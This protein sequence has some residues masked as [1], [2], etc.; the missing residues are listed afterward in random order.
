MAMLIK[1]V[2]LLEQI[3]Y[4]SRCPSR[5][6][7]RYLIVFGDMLKLYRNFLSVILDLL[8]RVVVAGK[9]SFFFRLWKL[10]LKHEN[11]G[12]LGNSK[13]LNAQE[14][15]VSQQCFI[16]I[17]ISCHFVV[18][19]IRHFHDKYPHLSVPLYLIGS[20]S[21][22]I[23][24]SKVEGMQGM[25]RAYDFHEF[26][27]CANTLNQL[28]AIEYG[29]NELQFG[30]THNKMENIWSKFHPLKD[31]EAL[32]DLEDHNAIGNDD[33]LVPAL[34]EGFKEVQCMLQVLNM[35]PSAHASEK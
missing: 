21:Y 30:R 31:G 2:Q 33:M 16:D 32:A 17:Q 7:F 15:F 28:S 23:L 19:L 1:D 3:A 18:L 6:L 24:F 25:E 12:V 22:E 4:M 13:S 26:F 27:S 29:T 11:H 8:C 5:E 35:A 10:W 9:V 14:S 34:K 20:D